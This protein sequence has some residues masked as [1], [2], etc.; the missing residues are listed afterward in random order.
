MRSEATKSLQLDGLD[1]LD[2]LED[3]LLEPAEPAHE[4]EIRVKAHTFRVQEDAEYSCSSET[5]L[6]GHD[7]WVTG[8]H[9]AP[10][11]TEAEPI[12][13]LSASADRSMILWEPSGAIPENNTSSIWTNTHRFGEF[14]SATNLGFFGALWGKDSAYVLAH[15]WGGSWH[16]WHRDE[17][18]GNWEPI[19]TISGHFSEVQSLAWE[20]RGEYLISAGADMTTRLHAPWRRRDAHSKYKE[21]WH[22][23]G[24][25]QIHGYSIASIAFTERL[26]FVSGAD[27]KIIR[28]FDAPKV[29]HTTLSSLA[30]IDDLGD[31]ESRPMAANVPPLGLSNRAIAGR[32]IQRR[33]IGRNSYVYFTRRF[34]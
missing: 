10:R 17:A 6:L 2:D 3:S 27:E 21:T 18:L 28:V 8:L 19:V 14:S 29:V 11:L 26:Q 34:S 12:R 4:D 16:V 33:S 25:P 20:P 7:A 15:G 23:L 31:V 24:R 5:V 13:L 30:V 22:E 9:W 32:S 1:A